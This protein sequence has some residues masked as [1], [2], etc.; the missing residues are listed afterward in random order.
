VSD[1]EENGEWGKARGLRKNVGPQIGI[2]ASASDD[3]TIRF[4]DYETGDF[5]GS[6]KG[7]LDLIQDIAFSADGTTLASASSDL[8]IKLWLVETMKCFKTLSGHEHVVQGVQ[9]FP[10]GTSLVSCSRDTTIKMWDISS[11]YVLCHCFELLLRL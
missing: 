6:L 9:F 7:H 4:W 10:S 3:G 11:G 1:D 5:K 2:L 8:T